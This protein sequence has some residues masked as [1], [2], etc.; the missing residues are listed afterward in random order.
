VPL[1]VLLDGELLLQFAKALVTVLERLLGRQVLKR[2]ERRRVGPPFLLGG[3]FLEGCAV[4][5]FRAWRHKPFVNLIKVLMNQ[6]DG[7]RIIRVG[8]SFSPIFLCGCGEFGAG[9][10]HPAAADLGGALDPA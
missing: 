1:G 9:L 8:K 3:E 2:R 4:G 10:R 5:F 6:A 7:G